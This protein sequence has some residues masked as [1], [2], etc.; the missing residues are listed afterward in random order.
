MEHELTLNKISK[1][2]KLHT[3]YK[4]IVVLSN[5]SAYINYK[6][7]SKYKF[8]NIV[9]NDQLYNYIKSSSNNLNIVYTEKK[10]KNICDKIL[11]YNNNDN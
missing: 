5:D 8:N 6:K 4:S 11:K 7:G 1:L 10:I 2:E 9:R 3:K